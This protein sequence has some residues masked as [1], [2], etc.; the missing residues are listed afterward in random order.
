MPAYAAIM[1]AETRAALL[2]YIRDVGCAVWQ[3]NNLAD[4]QQGGVLT[5]TLGTPF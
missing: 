3:R 4:N 2:Q 5:V 1:R